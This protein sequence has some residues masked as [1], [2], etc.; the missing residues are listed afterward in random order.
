MTEP[1]II[2]SPP[3]SFSSVVSTIIGQHPELYGFPELHLTVG[4]TVDEVIRHHEYRRSLE[5]P[6][7]LLRT[8][9]QLN[10]GVQTTQ[11][12]FKAR[13]WLDERR[14]WSTKKLF[15]YLLD[16]VSPK[17]AVEKSPITAM[18]P[19]F[20]ERI[21]AFFPKANYLHLT[22]HPI[23]TRA[24]MLEFFD[25]KRRVKRDP[26]TGLPI[27]PL[28]DWFNMHNNIMNL[29][30]TLPL[31]QCMRIKGEDV[32]SDPDL[33]LPQISEWLGIR[34]DVEAIEAMK[35]PE[36]SP[37]A[38]IGPFPARGGNDTKFMRSPRL[39]QGKVREPSLKDELEKGELKENLDEEFVEKVVKFAKQL[40]YR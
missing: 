36:D 6:P 32:L 16:K 26:T 24:S 13:A 18:K 29:T 37:Y 33:Y 23:P 30:N 22:R 10:Y 20:L 11:N 12:V 9:A 5:S 1:L 34:T 35:H 39:R 19:Q 40:G 4:D 28:K 2:L 8:L 21:Y 25:K 7:G 3:R 31:G 17:I 15:D 38:C 14:N 27:D